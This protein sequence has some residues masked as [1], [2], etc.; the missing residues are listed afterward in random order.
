M[1]VK[2]LRVA[3][4]SPDVKVSRVHALRDTFED[5]EP[6]ACDVLV[7][8]LESADL[9]PIWEIRK[10]QPDLPL[11]VIAAE[12]STFVDEKLCTKLAPAAL[13]LSPLDDIHS[14][15]LVPAIYAAV[16]GS[17]TFD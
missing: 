13:M 9:S 2:E 8:V 10:A 7:Y 4:Q 15:R 16:P 14:R 17:I 3:F 1:K 12:Q 11:V 6:G 5:A